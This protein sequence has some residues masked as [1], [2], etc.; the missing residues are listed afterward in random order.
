MC[1]LDDGKLAT[2][3]LSK[4]IA[5]HLL[6]IFIT[7]YIAT[8]VGKLH[9]CITALVGEDSRR[10][11]PVSRVTRPWA[12]PPKGWPAGLK[13]AS[14]AVYSFLA[15]A[16]G[17]IW[18]I[19]WPAWTWCEI[20][21]RHHSGQQL[22]RAKWKTQ[23]HKRCI[24]WRGLQFY[25]DWLSVALYWVVQQFMVQRFCLQWFVLIWHCGVREREDVVGLHGV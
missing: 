16:R 17:R 21:Y 14:E 18:I 12:S 19:N 20:W 10:D 23:K 2:V 11:V 8:V 25:P 7:L 22:P 9:Y 1:E 24:A 5:W 4:D 15:G 3:Q 13:M 6:L